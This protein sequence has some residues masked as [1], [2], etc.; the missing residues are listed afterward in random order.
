[1]RIRKWKRSQTCANMQTMSDREAAQELQRWMA[2]S[3]LSV[4]EFAAKVG[5]VA[6]QVSR[7]RHGKVAPG[8]LIATRIEA[9]TGGRVAAA[10][11]NA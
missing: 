5:C 9:I 1:M 4:K 3:G 6:E 7:Y 10:A 11:W 2:E 8:R